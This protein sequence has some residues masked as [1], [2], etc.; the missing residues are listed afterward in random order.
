LFAKNFKKNKVLKEILIVKCYNMYYDLNGDL[1]SKLLKSFK[2]GGIMKHFIKVFSLAMVLFVSIAGIKVYSTYKTIEEKNNRTPNYDEHWLDGFEN[3]SNLVTMETYE[4]YISDSNRVNFLI[5]GLEYVRTD[6][7]IFASYDRDTNKVDM[8]SIPRDTHYYKDGFRSGFDDQAEYK[9]NA[10]YGDEGIEGL[11][12]AV[13]DI[14]DLPIHHYAT[15]TLNGVEGVI[16]ALGGVEIDVPFDMY[17][18]DL[19]DEPPLLIDLKEGNQ[20]LDG[21]Q[22]VEFLRFRKSSDGTIAYGDIQRI[23]K[24]QEFMKK[25]IDKALSYRL[26]FIVDEVFDCFRTDMGLVDMVGYAKGA[27]GISRDDVNFCTLPGTD[28]YLG[29]TSFFL[30]DEA[31][32]KELVYTMYAIPFEK[33]EVE[34]N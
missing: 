7:L 25:A 34:E 18:E 12:K 4:A 22:S 3:D 27:V 24:Q 14:M 30:K 15:V 29:K 2:L 19:Y 5:V 28:K 1:Y 33:I 10:V 21:E 31:D 23:E 32:L 16:D 9:I 26:P 13:E 17:Y 8:I 11:L 6:T 20:I